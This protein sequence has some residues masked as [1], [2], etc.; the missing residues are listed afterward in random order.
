MASKFKLR[1]YPAG[2]SGI[3]L[4]LTRNSVVMASALLT[5][6]EP[7]GAVLR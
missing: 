1:H 7:N 5:N 4:A 6:A 3:A 2:K